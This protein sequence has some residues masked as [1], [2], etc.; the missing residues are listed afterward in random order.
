[1]NISDKTSFDVEGRTIDCRVRL[2]VGA[3]RG[4]VVAIHGGGQLSGYFDGQGDLSAME[5]FARHGYH[6][7]ACDRPGYGRNRDWSIGFDDQVPVLLQLIEAARARY[8]S[9]GQ[10]P[11]LFGNSIGG[12][13][14]LLMANERPQDVLGISMTGAGP[15]YRQP[16]AV[17]TIRDRVADAM[18]SGEMHSMAAPVV[19]GADSGV[20]ASPRFMGPPGTYDP[21]VTRPDPEREAPSLIADL[22]DAVAWEERFPSEAR[23]ARVPVQ[24]VIPEHDQLWQ[25]DAV[26]ADELKRWFPHVPFIEIC[27]QRFAAHSLLRHYVGYAHLLKTIGFIEECKVWRGLQTASSKAPS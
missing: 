19:V 22:K 3:V 20:S 8:G 9:P 1:M 12:M 17:S 23:R 21:A 18:A 2:A 27:A 4:L 15:V 5:V 24:L 14:S 11:F 7:L 10:P 26:A 13:L 25:A 6:V 16:G